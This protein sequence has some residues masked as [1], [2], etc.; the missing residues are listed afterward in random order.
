MPTDN[1]IPELKKFTLSVSPSHHQGCQQRAISMV[2]KC[3]CLASSFSYSFSK[4]LKNLPPSLDHPGIAIN[5]ELTHCIFGVVLCL[6][7]HADVRPQQ[8]A[9]V[10]AIF[11][12]RTCSSFFFFVFPESRVFFLFC[13]SIATTNF[14]EFGFLRSQIS[15]HLLNFPSEPS[16]RAVRSVVEDFIIVTNLQTVSTV[17]NFHPSPPVCS[18][19]T[20]SGNLSIPCFS[21][22]FEPSSVTL[23]PKQSQ[24]FRCRFTPNTTHSKMREVLEISCSAPTLALSRQ[25]VIVEAE[26]EPLVFGVHLEALP[27]TQAMLLGDLKETVTV[28]SVSFLFLFSF[29]TAASSFLFSC[30]IFVVV[31][32]VVVF[33]VVGI[34]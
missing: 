8:E 15:K 28:P 1:G 13:C 21:L 19:C 10:A 22:E 29:A 25:F 9:S 30:F 20:G 34:S 7:G 24:R 4:P 5:R 12:V 26:V 32:V 17:V 14:I 2:E 23:K 27:Q 3:K 11:Q 16:A 33:F 6:C 31:V 18:I